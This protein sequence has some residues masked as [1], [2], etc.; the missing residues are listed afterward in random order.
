MQLIIDISQSLQNIGQ[1]IAFGREGVLLFNALV[2]CK[3][4]N[5]Q[6]QH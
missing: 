5:S 4:L 1:I 3:T 2:C 6:L